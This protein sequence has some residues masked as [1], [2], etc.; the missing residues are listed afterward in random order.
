MH[1]AISD[2]AEWG[3]FVSGPE[4]IGPASREA[5]ERVLERIRSGRFAEEWIAENR[6]G[7]ARMK[8]FR[9]LDGEHPSE[10]VGAELRERMFKRSA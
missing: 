6:S 4:I 3:D 1:R 7:L 8:R 5:M 2:T 10:A 9:E